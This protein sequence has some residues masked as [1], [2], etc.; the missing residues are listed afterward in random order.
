MVY[1]DGWYIPIHSCDTYVVLP[2]HVGVAWAEF[3]SDHVYSFP[4]QSK[5][6]VLCRPF[7]SL[8]KHSNFG[9]TDQLNFPLTLW[10]ETT[11]E[12]FVSLQPQ[13]LGI[14]LQEFQKAPAHCLANSNIH[15]HVNY[16]F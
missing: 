7:D 8:R 9:V 3:V 4:H 5:A 16:Q 15:L 6:T 10:L 1:L 14:C 12:T 11:D 2:K 13:E